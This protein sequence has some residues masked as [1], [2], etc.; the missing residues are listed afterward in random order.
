MKHRIQLTESQLLK[1]VRKVLNET[2]DEVPYEKGKSGMRGAR[3]KADFEP[4]PKEAEIMKTLFGKYENDIPPIVV[5][6]LRKLGK[7]EL[8]KRLIDLNM[9]DPET[10]VDEFDIK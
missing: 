2:E 10:V 7:K 6:Y 5:R 4:Q 9:I 8:T 3:S 1:L